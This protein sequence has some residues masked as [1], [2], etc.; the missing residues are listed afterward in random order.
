[1]SKIY[2]SFNDIL[3]IFISFFFPPI[4]VFL[5][6]GCNKDLVINLLLTTFTFLFGVFHAIYVI[7][8]S[9]SDE[10]DTLNDQPTDNYPDNAIVVIL[11]GANNNNTIPTNLPPPSYAESEQLAKEQK[12]FLYPELPSYEATTSRDDVKH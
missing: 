9:T 12:Q 3:L 7:A 2:F 1:M 10:Y 11:P 4:S 6:S 8:K 5:K